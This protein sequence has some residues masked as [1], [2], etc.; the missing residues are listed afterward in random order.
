MSARDPR[1]LGWRRGDIAFCAVDGIRFAGMAA[2]DHEHGDVALTVILPL[3]GAASAMGSVLSGGLIVDDFPA[4]E[5][6]SSMRVCLIE[7]PVTQVARSRPLRWKDLQRFTSVPC[8][9]AVVELL[10]EPDTRVPLSS[11]EELPG[12]LARIAR[13]VNA[14]SSVS[15]PVARPSRGDL[16]EFLE[17]EGESDDDEGRD[18][19]GAAALGRLQGICQ[20][21]PRTLDAEL[22]DD[23]GPRPG[24][25]RAYGGPRPPGGLGLGNERIAAQSV[26]PAPPR[27]VSRT[28]DSPELGVSAMNA[29]SLEQATQLAILKQLERMDRRM[30]RDRDDS[31]SSEEDRPRR[32]LVLNF[33]RM[34]KRRARMRT[35]GAQMRS[36]FRT[37]VIDDLN[38]S[39]GQAWTYHDH[40]ELGKYSRCKSLGRASFTLYKAIETAD[41]TEDINQVVPILIQ[42]AKAFRQFSIDQ[43]WSKAWHLSLQRDPYEEMEFAGDEEELEDVAGYVDTREKLSAK[44]KPIRSTPTEEPPEKPTGRD[45]RR[46]GKNK[47]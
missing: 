9:D 43:S 45:G 22:L 16:D 5:G 6:D 34:R 23:G 20:P 2:K 15:A 36:R 17:H 3:N 47:D 24:I 39:P 28:R 10:A 40:W 37:Q 8:L 30:R 18:P 38:R 35:H 7:L 27:R 42:G 4:A 29:G 19:P 25:V 41:A 14:A 13:A 12:A 21:R 46:G 44:V 1:A 31:D 33:S 26:P 11:G 32:G